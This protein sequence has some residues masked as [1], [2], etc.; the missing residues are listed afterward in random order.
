M[1]VNHHICERPVL[2]KDTLKKPVRTN[3]GILRYMY[4]IYLSIQARIITSAV[5]PYSLFS[6]C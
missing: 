3:W 1:T 5:H 6:S 2:A 4:C